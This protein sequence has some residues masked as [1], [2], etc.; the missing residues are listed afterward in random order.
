VNERGTVG[1][2]ELNTRD[3]E[4]AK[5]FYGAVFGWEAD[6]HDMGEMG[7]YVE[8]RLGDKRVGGM[9][10]VRDR[11]PA[12]VPSHWLVYFSSVDTDEA[13]TKV[14]ELGGDVVFGPMD[15]PAGRFAVVRDSFGAVFAF[16]QPSEATI[17]RAEE[18]G[19]V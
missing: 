9:L 18:E 12:E 13:V 10:D 14:K 19:L 15:I 16:M 11:V 7:T 6:E 4:R 17:A 8:W 1:W 3:P 2:N 5:T